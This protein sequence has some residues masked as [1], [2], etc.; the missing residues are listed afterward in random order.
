MSTVFWRPVTIRTE[1][2][3]CATPLSLQADVRRNKYL[4]SAAIHLS[5]RAPHFNTIFSSPRTGLSTAGHRGP[6][7]ALFT[8]QAAHWKRK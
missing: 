6:G 2:M 4:G 1:K 3:L 7:V 8:K 5:N